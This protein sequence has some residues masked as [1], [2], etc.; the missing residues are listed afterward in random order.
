MKYFVENISKEDAKKVFREMVKTLHP[1]VG[2]DEEEFKILADEYATVMKG[3]IDYVKARRDAVERVSEKVDALLSIFA[4]VY[5]KTRV[6]LRYDSRMIEAELNE[7]VPFKKMLHIES[8]IR[9]FAPEL[10]VTLVFQRGGSKRLYNLTT[11]GNYTFINCKPED[12]YSMVDAKAVYTGRRYTIE[13]NKS[14]EFGTDSKEGHVYI[15]KRTSKFSMKE[16]FGV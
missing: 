8:I 11:V 15:L 7:T 5:P 12:E 9:K 6:M 4:E 2:G 16:L 10:D 13:K 3:Q 1:D 14:F